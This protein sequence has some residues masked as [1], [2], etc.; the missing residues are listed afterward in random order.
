MQSK[1]RASTALGIR[2]ME[3]PARPKSVVSSIS[4]WM[5]EYAKSEFD[6]IHSRSLDDQDAADVINTTSHFTEENRRQLESTLANVLTAIEQGKP[7][8]QVEEEVARAAVHVHSGSGKESP[9]KAKALDFVEGEEPHERSPGHKDADDK[10]K[11]STVRGRLMAKVGEIR[12]NDKLRSQLGKDARSF[13]KEIAVRHRSKP[14]NASGSGEMDVPDAIKENINKMG[15]STKE[16]RHVRIERNAVM[17]KIHQK[18]VKQKRDDRIQWRLASKQ[19]LVLARTKAHEDQLLHLRKVREAELMEW[20]M[21]TLLPMLAF[22]GRF[23]QMASI[24]VEDR[25]VRLERA[26][27]RRAGAVILR[28]LR[29][30]MRKKRLKILKRALPRMMNALRDWIHRYLATRKSKATECILEFAKSA[31]SIGD[32]P[33]A[34]KKYLHKVRVVQRNGRSHLARMHCIL[35]IRARQLHKHE[36]EAAKHQKNKPKQS[37]KSSRKM[38][39]LYEEQVLRKHLRPQLKK[40]GAKLHAYRLDLAAWRQE[41]AED[42]RIQED[43]A[44]VMQAMGLK[45]DKSRIREDTCGPPPAKPYLRIA[46]TPE[47]LK[48][49]VKEVTRLERTG[50]NQEGNTNDGPSLEEMAGLKPV[51]KKMAK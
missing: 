31:Q 3:R 21:R 19:R 28:C 10:L 15:N 49:L 40:L 34:V 12:Q 14:S 9:K 41:K 46:L 33:M 39:A 26:R 45:E 6:I 2:S 35:E 32:M 50:K 37:S 7:P 47:E 43:R 1:K 30:R 16:L 18:E 11:Q 29:R 4:N 38:K 13:M 25:S 22:C 8:S 44:A 5:N 51:K 24:L 20:R 27:H 48:L 36:E 17:R 42:D 23:G